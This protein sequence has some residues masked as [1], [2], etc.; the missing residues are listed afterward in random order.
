MRLLIKCNSA[1]WAVS[2]FA[3]FL[4]ESRHEPFTSSPIGSISFERFQKV[5]DTGGLMPRTYV[6]VVQHS[7]A[8]SP[9]E[10]SLPLSRITGVYAGG[11]DYYIRSETL[12]SILKFC[13]I[14][15]TASELRSYT[16]L[17]GSPSLCYWSWW[18]DLN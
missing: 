9:V 2:T 7:A 18:G 11:L 14:F 10:R 6:Q 8:I 13:V 12:A 4:N 16:D 17:I 3:A 15:L 5:P 1:A